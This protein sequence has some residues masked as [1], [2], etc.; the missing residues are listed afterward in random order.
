MPE[1]TSVAATGPPGT[2]RRAHHR[3]PKRRSN[4]ARLFGG[5]T[6]VALSYEACLGETAGT[7][8]AFSP[9]R[10]SAGDPRLAKGANRHD[11]GPHQRPERRLD[12]G[13]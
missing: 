8:F 5:P 13:Y 2:T 10:D 1:S 9:S 3:L 11:G 12:R 6:A 7:R 4:G